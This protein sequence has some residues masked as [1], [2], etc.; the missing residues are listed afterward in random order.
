M[1]ETML[2]DT[3]DG[4]FAF[5]NRR[6][7]ISGGNLKRNT[8]KHIAF[9]II[10]LFILLPPVCYG[11]S[12]QGLEY[13][14][15]RK[16]A[17]GVE[18]VCVGETRPLFQGSIRLK[19]AVRTNID[20]YLQRQRLLSMGARA[21]VWVTT[22]NRIVLYPA[23]IE[24][25]DSTPPLPN[26]AL[27]IASENFSLLQ[28]GLSVTVDVALE[29]GRL[30]PNLIL[31]FY[32]FLALL[33]LYGI[34]RT[35]IRKTEMEEA[36]LNES[37]R[38]LQGQA[39]EFS[40]RL[41]ELKVD[42]ESVSGERDRL[43]KALDDEKKKA[44]SNEAELFTE[45]VTL[46]EK[47]TRNLSLQQEQEKEIEALH[48]KISSYENQYKKA[49]APKAKETDVIAKRFGTLYKNI[50]VH[51]R[52]L[53]GFAALSEEAKIKA[54]EIIH[55]LN[56]APDQVAIKRKVFSGKGRGREAVLEV[57]FSY[58]GRLYFTWSKDQQVQVLTIGNKNTQARDL[59]FID[60]ISRRT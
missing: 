47:L 33:S 25:G 31:G 42:H 28:D 11:F 29:F 38:R 21:T 51:D 57:L 18:Q 26:E 45:I 49:R 40:R 20:R 7:G 60:K 41:A 55:R 5:R 59:E 34:Y 16:Y 50:S 12:V 8:M 36:E 1:I 52:A 39:E 32:I 3:A 17:H 46:D 56:E 14:L 13:Y 4:P 54:E 24:T 44:G 23:P 2:H 48:E 27:E 9:R 37:L 19:D 30:L 43:R 35:G 15:G 22:G 6:H 53:E 10:V 58:N